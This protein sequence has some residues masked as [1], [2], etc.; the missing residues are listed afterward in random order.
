V[1][2]TQKHTVPVA[3]TGAITEFGMVCPAVKLRFD[4]SESITHG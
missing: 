4:A 2:Y 1:P 3:D